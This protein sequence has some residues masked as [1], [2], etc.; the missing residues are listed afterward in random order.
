MTRPDEGERFIPIQRN[1]KRVE[2]ILFEFVHVHGVLRRFAC[3]TEGVPYD[4]NN[5]RRA[6]AASK[7]LDEKDIE[8]FDALERDYLGNFASCNFITDDDKRKKYIFSDQIWNIFVL[9]FRMG[10]D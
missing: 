2:L 10:I 5:P 6:L 1:G 3:Q 4:P 8:L 7:F 9:H